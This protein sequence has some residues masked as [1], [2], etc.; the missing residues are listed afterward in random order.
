MNNS[1]L[2]IVVGLMIGSCQFSRIDQPPTPDLSSYSF[3]EEG[4][5]VD[6]LASEPLLDAPVAIDFDWKGRIWVLEMRDYMPNIQGDE[7][8]PASRISILE[9]KN[10][11][12]VMDTRKV[13]ID[14]LPQARAMAHVYG[15]LLYAVP[16]NLYFAT[17]DKKDRII[18]QI[19]VDSQYVIAGNVEHQSN[20]LTLNL[21]NWIYSAKCHRRYKRTKTGEWLI[22]PSIRRGQWGLTHDAYGRLYYNDNSNALYSDKVLPDKASK[23]PFYLPNG[24][25]TQDIVKDRSVHPAHSTL[26]NRGYTEGALDT[27]GFV[28]E[29]TAVAG[30]VIYQGGRWGN[31]WQQVAFVSVPEANA[32]KRLDIEVNALAQSAKNTYAATEFLRSTDEGFRPVTLVNGPDGN[33]YIVD[34]HRGIIQ[35]K[36]YMTSYLKNLLQERGLDKVIGMGRI[37]RL[38]Q[39]DEKPF[40]ETNM[41]DWSVDQLLD[42]LGSKNAWLRNRAQQM[43]IMADSPLVDKKLKEQ[44][45][46][47]ID[48]IGALHLLR[49]LE[50]RGTLSLDILSAAHKKSNDKWLAAHVVLMANPLAPTSPSTY[51]ELINAL[52]SQN[53]P[54]VD[55]HL[56]LSFQEMR[57]I[58]K[59]WALQIIKDLFVRY[60]FNGDMAQALL[61]V[62]SEKELAEIQEI[63]AHDS[64]YLQE[65]QLLSDHI[66]TNKMHSIY[67]QTTGPEDNRGL[68]EGRVLFNTHCASCHDIGGE[69]IAN[70]APSLMNAHI[71]DS[72]VNNVVKTILRGLKGPIT[73]E[74]KIV[75]F[76]T[77]MPGLILNPDIS[78][79]DIA[80]IANYVMN[81]FSAK[82]QL[83]KADEVTTIRLGLSDS[84]ELLTEQEL[85]G[86]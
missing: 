54:I 12:G 10:K 29:L 82:P 30:A 25:V 49:T 67:R 32:L 6:V 15:G 81:A 74:G 84:Q 66:S 21:D 77:V 64:I 70:L 36:T 13:I 43:L 38:S 7:S 16:P 18:N 44:L 9:D 8:I 23:N 68:T 80:F 62:T 28:R 60:P 58:D 51:Q 40:T 2:V 24:L 26:I 22:E 42:V 34:M 27:Q 59:N 63:V 56:L 20:S 72:G 50:G 39:K 11:D 73:L 3:A 48:P 78:D 5:R 37:I 31:D 55:I 65:W 53:E 57:Q 83:I 1:I 46:G 85:L 79:T 47:I 35:H 75:S 76:N 86:K 33:L 4:F 69:G 19:V 52:I 61:T 45:S 14:S 71:V 17:F 41:S